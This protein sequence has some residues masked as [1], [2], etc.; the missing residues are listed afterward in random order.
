MWPIHLA[1]S[2]FILLNIFH[3]LTLCNTA[4][5]LTRSVQLISIFV[6]HHILKLSRYFWYTFRVSR[7]Q[8]HTMLCFKCSTLLVSSLI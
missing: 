2:L 6:Q 8:H 4:S 7:F 5:F 1:F 3:V